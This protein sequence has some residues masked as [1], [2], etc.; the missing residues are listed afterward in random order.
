MIVAS[1]IF[2]AIDNDNK[3]ISYSLDE[4]NITPAHFPRT[5]QALGWNAGL[6][7]V[8]DIDHRIK[9]VVLQPQ[10]TSMGDPYVIY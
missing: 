8:A 4:Q 7:E 1:N 2:V 10:R 9:L 6:V 5:I 3:I